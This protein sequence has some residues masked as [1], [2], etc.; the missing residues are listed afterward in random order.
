MSKYITD[1]SEIDLKFIYPDI[2]DPV[3]EELRSIC[4]IKI[5]ANSDGLE[6]ARAITGYV[7][8]LFTHDG[9]AIPPSFD[10]ITIINEARAGKSFRCVE[11]SFLA[12]TLL[13]AYDI[14][15]RMI[16]LKTKDVETRKYGAGHVVIEFWD[17]DNNHWSMCD[18][19]AGIIPEF[20]NK[21]LSA[22][23]LG[24][25]YDTDQ[26]VEVNPLPGSRFGS[27]PNFK[28][29]ESYKNWIHEYFYFF[30]TPL[31]TKLSYSGDEMKTEQRIMLVPKGVNPPLLFQNMFK[32]NMLYTHSTHDFH[33]IFSK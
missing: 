16:G 17:S 3:F 13:W 28:D 15:A 12:T 26:P 10:P 21:P 24:Q 29:N 27:T 33:P 11:Y 6:K 2:N 32:M 1:E 7:H 8:N 25:A 30:D 23:A 22:V 31:Q 19:Q 18:V 5:D 20:Q 4:N 14:P 9:D